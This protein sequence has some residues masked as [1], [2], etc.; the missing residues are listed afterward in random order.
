MGGGEGDGLR[1][2]GGVAGFGGIAMK[3][4]L[5]SAVVTAAL[6]KGLVVGLAIGGAVTACALCARRRNSRKRAEA[7]AGEAV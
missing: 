3:L 7:E 2:V 1:A 5:G 4:V 6:V